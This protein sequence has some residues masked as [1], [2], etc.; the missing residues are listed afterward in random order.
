MGR[1]VRN[2][3]SGRRLLVA[4]PGHDLRQ[5]EAPNREHVGSGQAVY[6]GRRRAELKQQRREGHVLLGAHVCPRAFRGRARL[7][8]DGGRRA[9]PRLGRE[10]QRHCRIERRRRRGR[11]GERQVHRERAPCLLCVHEH[12]GGRQR[13]GAD[14]LQAGGMDDREGQMGPRRGIRWNIVRLHQ[15]HG[16]FEGAPHV[17]LAAQERRE[18]VRRGQLRAG[19][20]HPE[21]RR[22]PQRGVGRAARSCGDD[23]EEP[24]SGRR[25][26]TTSPPATVS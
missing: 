17:E 12:G 11:G 9:L 26:A 19:G 3:R 22:H 6:L 1:Q 5:R 2:V 23:V 8:P 13:M 18:E 25:T 7:E 15:L 20:A 24:L 14:G 16:A 4:F 10:R 21:L